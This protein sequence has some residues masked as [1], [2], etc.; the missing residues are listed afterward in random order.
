[1]T[2]YEVHAKCKNCGDDDVIAWF[3][4][5]EDARVYAAKAKRERKS[6]TVTVVTER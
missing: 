3:D 2:T 1:M 4:D 5:E 6:F